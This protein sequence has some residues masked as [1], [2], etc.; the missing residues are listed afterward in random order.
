MERRNFIK[1]AV[2]AVAMVGLPSLVLAESTKKEEVLKSENQISLDKA[3][4]LI[5]GKSKVEQSDKVKLL[6]PLIAENS[7]VVPVKVEV[8]YPMEKEN[9]VKSIHILSS[10]NSNTRTLDF[11]LTPAN[12]EASFKTKIKLAKSQKVMVLVGL[13]NGTFLKAEKAIKVTIGTC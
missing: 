5:V 11:F 3:V 10:E 6:M 8:D 1:T 2:T 7:S 12:A 4:A 9:Y 13:S